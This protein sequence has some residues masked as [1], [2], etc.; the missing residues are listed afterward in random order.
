MWTVSR[1]MDIAIDL[2]NA[3]PEQIWIDLRQHRN[4][5]GDHAVLVGLGSPVGGLHQRFDI[6]PVR[7]MSC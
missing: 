7:K 6:V 4:V 1:A 5:V 3:Y 2:G